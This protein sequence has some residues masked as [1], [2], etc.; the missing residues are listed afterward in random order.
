MEG[1]W[2]DRGYCRKKTILVKWAQ[3]DVDTSYSLLNKNNNI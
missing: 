1:D 3:E 2:N